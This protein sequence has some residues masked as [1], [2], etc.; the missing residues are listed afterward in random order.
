MRAEMLSLVLMT[1]FTTA[2]APQT[3]RTREAEQGTSL[4]PPG[5]VSVLPLFLV[6]A[7]S[8]APT[9]EQKQALKRHLQICRSR[10]AVVLGTREG[11][12]VAPGEPKV[13][14]SRKSLADLHTLPEDSAPEIVAT[15]LAEYKVNRFTCPYIFVTVV[16]NA[17]E[18]WPAG[19][20]RPLNGGFN[21]GGGIVI[22]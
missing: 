11:F 20:G 13:I 22:L 21:T 2:A 5:Q 1:T 12:T 14:R 4:D 10:Y 8:A 7:G 9:G 17:Q 15:L 16:M 19:G 6:P 3:S 18:D